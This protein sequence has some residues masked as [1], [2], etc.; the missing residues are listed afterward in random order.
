MGRYR[1]VSLFL[2]PLPIHPDVW[3]FFVFVFTL[4]SSFVSIIKVF[5]ISC[6]GF[7]PVRFFVDCLPEMTQVPLGSKRWCYNTNRRRTTQCFGVYEMMSLLGRRD[8]SSV[9]GRIRKKLWLLVSAVVFSDAAEMDS[10]FTIKEII[11]CFCFFFDL[12]FFFIYWFQILYECVFNLWNIN[13]K[14]SF[15]KHYDKIHNTLVYC[16]L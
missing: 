14:L 5:I 9:T 10:S 13:W 6:S 16:L 11:S 8:G 1:I 2:C 7:E 12:C 15:M 3:G 4:L